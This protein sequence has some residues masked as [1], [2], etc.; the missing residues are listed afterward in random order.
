LAFLIT[1]VTNDARS[2][3]YMW[4]SQTVVY[5]I[6]LFLN[7]CFHQLTNTCVEVIKHTSRTDS[8]AVNETIITPDILTVTPC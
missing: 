7:Y 3:K 5:R 6:H 1:I 2:N 8:Y 4:V